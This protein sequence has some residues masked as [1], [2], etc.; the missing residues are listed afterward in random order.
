MSIMLMRLCVSAKGFEK[1]ILPNSTYLVTDRNNCLIVIKLLCE[2]EIIVKGSFSCCHELIVQNTSEG[3]RERHMLAFSTVMSLSTP[4]GWF[5]VRLFF[6]Y[7]G[8]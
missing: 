2:T 8:P 1:H 5:S 6:S 3:L 7:P 4:L